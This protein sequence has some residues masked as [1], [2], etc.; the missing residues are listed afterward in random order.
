MTFASY[1]LSW[2]PAAVICLVVGLALLIFEMFSPGMGVPALL[3]VIALIASIVL[4]ADSFAH[5]LISLALILLLLGVF[6]FFVFRAFSK[7]KLHRIVLN[8]SVS[9]SSTP[10]AKMK[11]L[12]GAQGV[13]V[14]ALR[15][16]GSAEFNGKKLDVVSDGEFI[17]KGCRVRIESVEGLRITVG[18]AAE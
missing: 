4:S 3:G 6:A 13:C 9:G 8:E 12:V 16:S 7:G 15:P 14:T 18:K 5:A 2:N 1:I 11:D 10:L 17:D